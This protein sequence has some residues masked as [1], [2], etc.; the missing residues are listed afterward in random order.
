MEFLQMKFLNPS[1]II[2]HFI[3]CVFYKASKKIILQKEKSK[4]GTE[5]RNFL[6]YEIFL[7]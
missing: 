1:L 7:S 2:L 4:N 5:G 3:V 6:I